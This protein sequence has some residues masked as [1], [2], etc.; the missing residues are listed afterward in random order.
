MLQLPCCKCLRNLTIGKVPG[1]VSNS[2][3]KT[4]IVSLIIVT[5]NTSL[6]RT[7]Q[8]LL[9]ILGEHMKTVVTIAIVE[10][11]IKL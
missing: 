4:E 5:I 8:N 2:L 11:N 9:A 1:I 3:G 6:T 7:K 10:G